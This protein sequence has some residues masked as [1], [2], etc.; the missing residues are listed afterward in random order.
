MLIGT[1]I[2]GISVDRQSRRK[3][4]TTRV[5]STTAMTSVSSVSCRLARMVGVRSAARQDFDVGGHHRLQLRQRGVHAS[6]DVEDIGAGLAEDDHEHGRLAVEQAGVADVLDGILH[7]GDVGQPNRAAV[8]IGDHQRRGSPPPWLAW[9]LVSSCMR[10][11]AD[12]DRALRRIGVGRGERGAH[13]FQ[14]DA[15]LVAAPAGSAPPAPPAAPRRRSSPGRRRTVATAA[16]AARWWPR[17][18]SG[19]G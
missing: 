11:V 8:A 3:T 19:R 13:V 4:N 17:R 2:A 5:T 16:A 12:L 7:V 10:C 18:T 14:P 15:E 1:A 9:S 6:D